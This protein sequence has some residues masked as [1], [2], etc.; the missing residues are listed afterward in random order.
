MSR[1]VEMDST[2]QVTAQIQGRVGGAS[3]DLF[4]LL[5]GPQSHSHRNLPLAL[6]L[7]SVKLIKCWLWLSAAECLHL[8]IPLSVEIPVISLSEV[9]TWPAFCSPGVPRLAW[10]RAVCIVHT[11]LS[12]SAVPL[13]CKPPVSQQSHILGLRVFVVV[14]VQFG[15]QGRK[16]LPSHGVQLIGKSNSW[17]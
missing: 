10:L 6:A 9:W 3:V 16:A 15:M 17:S 2:S 8:C 13:E 11:L 14:Q 5:R 1:R 12:L 7:Q 4:P